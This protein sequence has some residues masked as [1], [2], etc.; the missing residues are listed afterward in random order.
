MNTAHFEPGNRDAEADS[1]G[2]RPYTLTRGRTQASRLLRLETLVSTVPQLRDHRGP[3]PEYD[4]I[5]EMCV[6]PCSVAE[7]SAVLGIPVG[8]MRILVADLADG[9]LVQVHEQDEHGA[10]TTM[11]ERVLRGLERL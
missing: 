2:P 8:V 11:L 7:I 9:G 10:S 5:R 1:F 6:R 4:R 3:L